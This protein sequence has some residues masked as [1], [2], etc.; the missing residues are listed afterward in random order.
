MAETTRVEIVEEI[1]VKVEV[2]RGPQGADGKDGAGVSQNK[3]T[4]AAAA[5]GVADSV[6]VA[7]GP[8]A[9]W[10]LTITDNVTG[11]QTLSEIWAGNDGTLVAHTRYGINSIGAAVPHTV[12]VVILAGSMELRVANTG[13][14]T[15]TSRA[16]RI[17]TS[18]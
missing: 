5:T 2:F 9:K 12:D 16:V 4:I 11:D 13:G 18:A 15:V 1:T 6:A 8:S 14:N 7:L 3:I 17:L 10:L